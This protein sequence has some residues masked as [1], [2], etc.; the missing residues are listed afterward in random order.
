MATKVLLVDDDQKLVSL[1]E[2]GMAYEGFDVVCA[3][4]GAQAL[5]VARSADPHVVLLDIGMP[6]L[7]GFETCR[8]LRIEH[9]LPVIMLTGLDAISDKVRAFELGA[10]DYLTKPFALEELIVRIRAVL[11][12]FGTGNEP[13]SYADLAIDLVTH[14]TRRGDRQLDLTRKEFE[15]LTLF[16]RHPRQVLTRELLFDRLWGLDAPSDMNALEAHVARLRRKMEVDGEARLIE[17]VR[18]IGYS[19]RGRVEKVSE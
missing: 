9:D 7:D 17:T 10:D 13:L 6:G 3:N 18:G 12:R 1:V 11:R 2:R 4:D 19:L 16:V 14:T 5:E 15:L 8:R